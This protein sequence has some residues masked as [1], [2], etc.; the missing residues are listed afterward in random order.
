MAYTISIISPTDVADHG[1][2]PL[3][4]LVSGVGEYWVWPFQR[5]VIVRLTALPS[6]YEEVAQVHNGQEDETADVEIVGG[7]RIHRVAPTPL[8]AASPAYR[9]RLVG[10]MPRLAPGTYYVRV[11]GYDP[12]TLHWY[13]RGVTTN[14]LRVLA[15]VHPDEVYRVRECWPS[16]PY[17]TGPR[18]MGDAT[19]IEP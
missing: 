9:R 15:R 19:M 16:P 6:T 10:Y 17:Y 2:D 18:S 7:F 12:A 14:A 8:D 3:V 4:T 13:D 1:G 11:Y 5:M